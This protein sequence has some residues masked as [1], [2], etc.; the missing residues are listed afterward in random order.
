[1]VKWYLKDTFIG[2]SVVDAVAHCNDRYKS[3]KIEF[4]KVDDL[5]RRV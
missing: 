1:M 3:I 2:M 5:K 4:I